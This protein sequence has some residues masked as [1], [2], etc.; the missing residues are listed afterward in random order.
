MRERN[1]RALLFLG[2]TQSFLRFDWY[3]RMFGIKSYINVG[4]LLRRMREKNLVGFSQAAAYC[5]TSSKNFHKLSRGELPRLDALQRIC[6]G[7]GITEDELIVGMSK[8][9]P[10][11]PAPVIEIKKGLVS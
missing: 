3:R 1:R 8:S 6:R 11:E 4:L 10:A 5:Q 2:L 7:L 9:K